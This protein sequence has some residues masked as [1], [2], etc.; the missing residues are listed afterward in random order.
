[1]ASLIARP[2][3]AAAPDPVRAARPA[4]TAPR[5]LVLFEH[6]GTFRFRTDLF[7]NTNLTQ[8]GAR[9]DHAIGANLRLRYEP[10]LRISEAFAVH[11]TFDLLGR[12]RLGEVP[13]FATGEGLDGD[14]GPTEGT[15]S[16]D[17]ITVSHLFGSWTPISGIW[18]EAGRMP[19]HFG[20]GLVDNDGTC[21]DCDAQTVRDQ[22]SIRSDV[23][24][25]GLRISWVFAAEGPTTERSRGTQGQPVD[26]D[27]LDDL[28]DWIFEVNSGYPSPLRASRRVAEARDR[29]GALVDWALRLRMRKADL[30]SDRCPVEGACTTGQQVPSFDTP[31][32]QL[33][34]VPRDMRLFFPA[35]FVQLQAWPA[36]AVH[37]V[38]G[39]ELH[40]MLGEIGTTQ[41]VERP[42]S[43]R[44][45][46]AFA[47]AI[48]TRLALHR[49]RLKLDTVVATGDP[50][51]RFLG[52][53]DG[54]NSIVLDDR[55]FASDP[56]ASRRNRTF[57]QMILSRSF[58]VDRILFREILGAVTNTA[59]VRPS[60]GYRFALGRHALELQGG[61]LM[62]W[63]L[64][65]EATPGRARYYGAEVDL[66][67]RA[68]IGRHFQANLGLALLAAGRRL[69]RC[70]GNGR[71]G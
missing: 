49:W 19:G 51:G 43:K 25:V 26:A 53:R 71:S 37:L 33:P 70:A 7:F 32:D 48:Q 64:A 10:T 57:E 6:A 41:A 24:G 67:A 47:G 40:A 63:A 13:V 29:R 21:P 16:F 27:Q 3:I 22:V 66:D 59:L 69:H 4:E 60:V 45:V 65:P 62:A 38:L 15:F 42:T 61:T 31:L 58:I 35:A 9:P 56:E 50:Q 8:D 14:R 36:A 44:K 11:A 39:A 5:G 28:N 17:D 1:M 18:L 52:V 54:S 12:Q 55:D 34:L 2:T 20:L 30:Q 46:R 23:F 68:F